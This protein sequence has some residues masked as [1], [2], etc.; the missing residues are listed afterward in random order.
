MS[1]RSSPLLPTTLMKWL[2]A[3]SGR[4]VT[5]FE[6]SAIFGTAYCRGAINNAVNGF[7]L[8]RVWLADS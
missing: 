5:Q 6:V 8:P 7:A 4:C 2:R 3:N 1:R